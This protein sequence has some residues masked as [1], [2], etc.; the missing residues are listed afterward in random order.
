LGKAETLKTEMLR[1]AAFA[2]A[3]A[4]QGGQM[5][6]TEHGGRELKAEIWKAENRNFLAHLFNFSFQLSVFQLFR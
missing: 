1:S 4:S 5:P 2:E 6:D 3:T